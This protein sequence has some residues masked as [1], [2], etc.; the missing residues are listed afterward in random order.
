M[1]P[2]NNC[3]ACGP[4]NRTSDPSPWEW[5]NY[6]A[7]AEKHVIYKIFPDHHQNSLTF[8]VSGNADL[9]LKTGGFHWSKFH[10]LHIFADQ[11][12]L[13]HLDQKTT[14]AFSLALRISECEFTKLCFLSQPAD[15]GLVLLRLLSFTHL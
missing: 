7:T 11:W 3:I 6:N 12:Q 15:L 2:R 8:Q 1:D 13:L 4:E 9:H 14:M 10:C 5:V